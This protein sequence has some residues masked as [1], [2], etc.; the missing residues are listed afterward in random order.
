M[1]KYF[2]YILAAIILS[3]FMLACSDESLNTLPTDSVSGEGMFS[4]ATAALVPLNG[5]YRMMYTH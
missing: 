1:K 2:I 4:N 5:I 3:N